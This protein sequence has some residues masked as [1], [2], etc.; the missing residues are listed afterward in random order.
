MDILSY[1]LGKK[2]SGG[3]GGGGADTYFNLTP[4]TLSTSLSYPFWSFDFVKEDELKKMTIVVPDSTTALANMFYLCNWAALP[5]VVKQNNK[6]TSINSMYKSCTSL[7]EAIDLSQV[8]VS[9]VTNMQEAFSGCVAVPEITF[10]DQQAT[11]MTNI[12]SMFAGCRQLQKLD[13]RGFS[14]SKV[15]SSNNVFN[16]VPTDCLIIVKDATEKTWMNT[17]F[18]TMTNVKTVEEYEG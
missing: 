14:F 16:N 5:K 7:V 18:P 13:I 12:T 8:N 4:T 1:L 3:G 15:A 9:K 17:N 6:L 2:S 10:G 11:V